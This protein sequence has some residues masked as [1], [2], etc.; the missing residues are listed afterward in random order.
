MTGT[1]NLHVRLGILTA[2]TVALIVAAPT[3]AGID[4]HNLRTTTLKGTNVFPGPGDPDGSGSALLEVK[5]RARKV[6]FHVEFENLVGAAGIFIHKGHKGRNG[7]VKVV[8]LNGTIDKPSPQQDLA[9]DEKR[10]VL[11]DMLAHPRRYY[12]EIENTQFPSGAVRGQLR[13]P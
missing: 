13:E 11:R 12:L 5:P 9:S 3:T 8:L 7:P 6:I 4:P 10:R 1:P 2:A